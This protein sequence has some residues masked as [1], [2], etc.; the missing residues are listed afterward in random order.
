MS[1]QHRMIPYPLP[2]QFTEQ[3]E[4]GKR[5]NLKYPLDVALTSFHL[6]MVFYDRIRIICTV[7]QQLVYEDTYDQVMHNTAVILLWI[8]DSFLVLLQTFGE[9]KGLSCDARCARTHALQGPVLWTFA[10]YALFR[11]TVF[12]ESRHIWQVS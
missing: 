7:S 5:R 3:T 1:Q 9:L 10:D 4:T 11:Y 8:N 2:E 12:D 6:A